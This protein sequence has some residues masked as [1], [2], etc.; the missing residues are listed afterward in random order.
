MDR[1]GNHYSNDDDRSAK[2]VGGHKPNWSN[3][4]SLVTTVGFFAGSSEDLPVHTGPNN[5]G[6][7]VGFNARRFA[8]GN[9][10]EQDGSSVY[11][12]DVLMGSGSRV[13]LAATMQGFALN[14]RQKDAV[15]PRSSWCQPGSTNFYETGAVGW[16][17]KIAKVILVGGDGFIYAFNTSTNTLSRFDVIPP[18]GSASS[19]GLI[20][21]TGNL[22]LGYLGDV[23]TSLTGLFGVTDPSIPSTLV[24]DE[25]A[26]PFGMNIDSYIASQ[27]PSTGLLWLRTN[28]FTQGLCFKYTGV[29]YNS[30]T[31]KTTFTGVTR[32]NSDAWRGP[33]GGQLTSGVPV[34]AWTACPWMRGCDTPGC[35]L[36][37]GDLLFIANGTS[38][39][40]TS[41]DFG[42][43]HKLYKWDGT[44]TPA[45]A[46]TELRAGT[47]IFTTLLPLPDGSVM[48][49]NG[50]N[51]VEFFLPDSAELTPMANSAP[52][53]DT[54]PSV[55]VSSTTPPLVG[56]RLNG[57]IDGG[58][59]NDEGAVTTA[60]PIAKFRNTATNQVTYATCA[61]VA[62]R[63][64]SVQSSIS[65]S[66]TVDVPSTLRT[67][68]YQLSLVAGGI[69][70]TAIPIVVV[71]PGSADASFIGRF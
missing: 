17:E 70:G 14:W 53:I 10:D 62:L 6:F 18:L 15:A 61:R 40:N 28:N 68:E 41:G 55:A 20:S 34:E 9:F 54:F 3:T 37:N 4:P 21:Q 46:V 19:E 30:S 32:N 51:Q 71:G 31:K 16:M 58:L 13:A 33:G 44:T 36:P 7:I 27:V 24:V 38:L 50:F 8:T 60:Y 47:G 66:C 43:H 69:E 59:H 25:P 56:R 67:G 57:V 35:F 48:F 45:V 22:Y 26:S 49:V 12:R 65:N 5:G 2:T 11:K 1:D 64:L 39:D 42:S 52:I 29:S 23:S 63:G